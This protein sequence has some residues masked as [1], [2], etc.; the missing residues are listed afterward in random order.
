MF[1][2]LG[3]VAG[4]AAGSTGSQNREEKGIQGT[5]GGQQW[6]RKQVITVEQQELPY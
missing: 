6:A 3:A 4:Q 2:L 5:P 1:L